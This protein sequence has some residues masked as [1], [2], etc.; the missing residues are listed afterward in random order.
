MD[1]KSILSTFPLEMSIKCENLCL[2]DGETNLN[3]VCVMYQMPHENVSKAHDGGQNMARWQE[4]GR[5]EK[6]TNDKNPIWK[7]KIAFDYTFG[8]NIMVKFEVHHVL[9]N[10]DWGLIGTTEM[11]TGSSS[12]ELMGKFETSLGTLLTSMDGK[13]STSLQLYGMSDDW[14]KILGNDSLPKIYLQ[15]SE[16]DVQKEIIT[17]EL[18][19]ENLDNKDTFGTSDPYFTI[20]SESSDGQSEL[21]YRS[22][23]I[24]NNLNPRWRP[25]Q[26]DMLK[27]CN[28]DYNKR[29]NFQV[30]DYDSIGSHDFIGSFISSMQQLQNDKSNELKIEITNERKRGTN[31]NSGVVFVVRQ[32]I[33]IF[34]TFIK[35]L[36]TE[37]KISLSVAFDFTSSN[38]NP[39]DKSSLHYIYANGT[40]SLYG[41]VARSVVEGIIS[42]G[43]SSQSIDAYGFGAKLPKHDSTSNIFPLNLKDDRTSTFSKFEDM[44][45]AYE[46]CAKNVEFSKPCNLSPVINHVAKHA[47]TF[48]VDGKQYFIL[49]LLTNGEVQDL[50]ATKQAISDVSQWPLSIVIVGIGS[51]DFSHLDELRADHQTNTFRHRSKTNVIS[52]PS[53]PNHHFVE[54]QKHLPAESL[55]NQ[56]LKSRRDWQ[57]SL[58]L[59]VLSYVPLQIADWMSKNGKNISKT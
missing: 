30:Y 53:R 57:K 59:E 48:M 23:V 50:E 58:A 33:E 21:V 28:G 1:H 17:F 25:F 18:R 6:I 2:F 15:I 31:K 24:K 5:T 26:L 34:P 39:S 38:G 35:L 29:L 8:D 27:L 45:K 46:N 14:I 13:Y 40:D 47:Q 32:D 12:Q 7:N 22:E 44:L 54:L 51:K 56:S 10:N 43:C 11:D 20:S 55:Q 3:P 36:Q 9:D 37:A 42:T 19:A 52:E 49:L 4:V 16:K 41:F